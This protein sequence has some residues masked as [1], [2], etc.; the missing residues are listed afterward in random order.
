MNVAMKHYHF[1]TFEFRGGMAQFELNEKGKVA[2]VLL[3]LEE[4]VKPF[5][6]ERIE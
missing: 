4:A 5:A 2:R 3:P 1:D 6:F